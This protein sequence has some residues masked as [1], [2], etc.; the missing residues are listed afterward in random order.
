MIHHQARQIEQAGHPGDH[1]DEMK[2]L[3]PEIHSASDSIA[4]A[5]DQLQHP[6]HM[7]NGCLGKNAMAEVEDER[8]PFR[9]T[10]ESVPQPNRAPRRQPPAPVGQGCPEASAN[11]CVS[12]EP[13][14]RPS[15]RWTTHHSPFRRRNRT[16]SSVVA[17]RGKPMIRA[18]GRFDLT[19]LDN[20][21]DWPGRPALETRPSA[22]H[23]PSCR[24]SAPRRPPHPA[25]PPD[26][27]RWPPPAHRSAS[28][29]P[30]VAIG[31]QPR[32]RLI[33]LIQRPL[34]M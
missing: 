17:P 13:P 11:R 15:Y 10:L 22:T 12:T 23:P 14:R 24:R 7:R 33:F 26:D 5:T 21:L 32:S 6:L 28:G 19:T 31:E 25:A 8:S 18:P 3:E 9:R 27:R 29:M 1:G 34:I 16:R 20:R 2:G 30:P 4:S